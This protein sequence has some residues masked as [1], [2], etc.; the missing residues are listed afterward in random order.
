MNTTEDPSWKRDTETRI[1]FWLSEP[2]IVD[3]RQQVT[4]RHK[5]EFSRAG[6]TVPSVVLT[7]YNPRGCLTDDP[8]N[9]SRTADLARIIQCAVKRRT[10]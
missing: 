9:A 3:L 2:V 7:A 1:R 5:V 10:E 4:S 6:L 8:T